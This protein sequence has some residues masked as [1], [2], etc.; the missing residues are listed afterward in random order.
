MPKVVI[1]Y[2]KCKVVQSCLENC[3]AD[4]FEMQ[5]GKMVVAREEDCTDCKVCEEG[6]P[7]GAI[8]VTSD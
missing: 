3:P 1:N 5:D 8:T 4:V 2:D 7:E 6:C